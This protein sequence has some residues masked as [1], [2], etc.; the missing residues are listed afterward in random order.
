MQEHALIVQHARIIHVV[1]ALLPADQ[2]FELLRQ[3][4]PF[5]RASALPGLVHLRGKRVDG[6]AALSRRGLRKQRCGRQQE[7]RGDRASAVHAHPHELSNIFF[8]TNHF[9]HINVRRS[10]ASDPIADTPIYGRRSVRIIRCCDLE[11]SLSC[12]STP[13]I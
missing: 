12:K 5:R 7:D 11:K 9:E 10:S 1:G 6:V 8:R 13:A 2:T 4:Q 3:R